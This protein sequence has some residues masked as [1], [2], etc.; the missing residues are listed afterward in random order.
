MKLGKILCLLLFALLLIGI[1][2]AAGAAEAAEPDPTTDPVVLTWT[3]GSYI[4]SFGENGKSFIA[5][6]RFTPDELEAYNFWT[7][8]RV[9]FAVSDNQ[10]S[11]ISAYTVKVWKCGELVLGAYDPGVLVCSQEMSGPPALDE[12]GW[13]TVE[14]DSPVTVEGNEEL[15][16]GIEFTDYGDECYPIK[17]ASISSVDPAKGRF[18][19]RTGGVY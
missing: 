3:D 8:D 12:N 7:L 10:V 1:L 13:A 17:V 2:P 9:V 15:W 6:A 11:G 16:I 18:I 19:I 14:L 4:S 5:A